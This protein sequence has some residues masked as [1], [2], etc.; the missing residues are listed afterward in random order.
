MSRDVAR[1]SAA[2]DALGPDIL[3]AHWETGDRVI[4]QLDVE[5]QERAP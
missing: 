3:I 4:T 2:I 5:Y 1:F